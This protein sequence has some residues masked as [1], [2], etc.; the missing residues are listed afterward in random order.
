MTPS[1]MTASVAPGSAVNQR[2]FMYGESGPKKRREISIE[3]APFVDLPCH[4]QLAAEV[5]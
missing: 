2:A 1:G 4:V 5:D 3:H